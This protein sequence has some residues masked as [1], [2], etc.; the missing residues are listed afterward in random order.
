MPLV[1]AGTEF[2]SDCVPAESWLAPS[3]S[4][5]APAFNV[6]LFAV[7]FAAPALS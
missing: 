7:S 3:L 6:S 1:S 4:F 2:M 5:V